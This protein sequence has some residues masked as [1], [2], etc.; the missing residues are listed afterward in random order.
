MSVLQSITTLSS[1][2]VAGSAQGVCLIKSMGIVTK[3]WFSLS[4]QVSILV[5][6]GL[7][8]CLHK[9]LYRFVPFFKAREAPHRARY[10]PAVVR[11]L[12]VAYVSLVLTPLQVQFR[13]GLDSNFSLPC[14]PFSA[15]STRGNWFFGGMLRSNASRTSKSLLLVGFSFSFQF[16]CVTIYFQHTAIV[17][18]LFAVPF[19]LIA[20][21]QHWISGDDLSQWQKQVRHVLCVG[22][23]NKRRWWMPI[24]LLRRFA[25]VMCFTL[26]TDLNLRT[27]IMTLLCLYRS[28]GICFVPP[29]V[30]QRVSRCPYIL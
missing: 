28:F 14:R 5:A 26:V 15:L 24:T 9:I 21:L 27:I 10:Y 22:F 17:S 6:F 2:G 7:I 1:T 8:F 4:L 11:F 30:W 18:L 19:F 20:L 16:Q 12:L 13:W 23:R 25:I 3:L 29:K